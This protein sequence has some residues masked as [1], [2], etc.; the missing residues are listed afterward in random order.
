MYQSPYSATLPVYPVVL[1]KYSHRSPIHA[2]AFAFFKHDYAFPRNSKH[3][4]VTPQ[5]GC[6]TE[7][8]DMTRILMFPTSA[9]AP[10]CS[11]IFL[12]LAGGA[13]AVSVSSHPGNV[14]LPAGAVASGTRAAFLGS[15]PAP[16]RSPRGLN[17]QLFE[18]GLS[19]R[20]AQG[21]LICGR[22]AWVGG[23]G[24]VDSRPRVAAAATAEIMDDADAAKIIDG[25]QL[26][27]S[28]EDVIYGL[29]LRAFDRRWG[30]GG[31]A[32][33]NPDLSSQRRN[34]NK[35][36]NRAFAS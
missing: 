30:R 17:R 1:R 8:D 7:P 35:F 29:L 31:G 10:E 19:I 4:Q 16:V 33:K 26:S 11:G 32:P 5:G 23:R 25:E 28:G 24:P 14:V 36:I 20:R 22:R 13:T 3:R 18:S 2:C 27:W 15:N 34:Q 6:T 12:L 21:V 9:R